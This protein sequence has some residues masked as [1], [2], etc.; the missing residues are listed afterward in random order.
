MSF[1]RVD[2]E[3]YLWILVCSKINIFFILYELVSKIFG[4]AQITL[5]YKSKFIFAP[6]KENA[7]SESESR[8]ALSRHVFFWILIFLFSI[9]IKFPL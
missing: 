2:P 4:T 3:P 6:L 7:E 1:P 5:I 9:K 8:K